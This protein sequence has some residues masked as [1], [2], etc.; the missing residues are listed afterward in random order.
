MSP[1]Q[2]KKLADLA[3]SQR[4][5]GELVHHIAEL[6]R[7]DLPSIEKRQKIQLSLDEPALL[8]KRMRENV[9]ELE[10]LIP[11]DSNASRL[12]TL[13]RCSIRAKRAL[14]LAAALSAYRS[15]TEISAEMLLEALASTG[16]RVTEIL[17]NIGHYETMKPSRQVEAS[18][19]DAELLETSETV[20]HIVLQA[21]GD[22]NLF[23]HEV[24][25]AEHLLLALMQLHPDVLPGAHEVRAATLRTLK[26]IRGRAS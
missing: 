5:G 23:K 13:D 16:D 20:R 10:S 26:E 1:E 9:A 19:R 21:A 2:S 15:Q 8:S 25:D 7:S 11:K 22:A 4:R 24:I 3:A 17:R 14:L 12:F 6:E 18:T